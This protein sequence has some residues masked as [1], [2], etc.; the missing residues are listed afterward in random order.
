MIPA[1]G[2]LAG[3]LGLLLLFAVAAAHAQSADAMEW[4]RKIHGATHKLSYTG[5]FVY[6]QGART[7]TSRITRYV[8][9]A[10]EIEKLEAL[11]GVPREIVRTRDMVRCYLPDARVVKVDRRTGEREFPA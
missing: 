4:L 7:E 2:P 8:D 3:P 1:A 10:G 11:D 9:H 5:T 6:Q